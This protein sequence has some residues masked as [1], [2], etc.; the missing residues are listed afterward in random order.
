MKPILLLIATIITTSASIACSCGPQGKL[1]RKSVQYAEAVFVGTVVE[2]Y[3]D[4]TKHLRYLVFEVTESLKGTTNGEL[5]TITTAA[6]SAACG[7]SA[8]MKE[9][10]Y[11]YA[12]TNFPANSLLEVDICG[13]STRLSQLDLHGDYSR[14]Y[15]K[16]RK[17]NYRKKY[18]RFK[19]D[20]R[21]LKRMRLV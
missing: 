5:V 4:S 20:R 15:V 12:L 9:S 17:R 18:A 19:K 10:W 16:T 1:D 11:I 2:T 6:S 3:V 14:Q 13:R 8:K 21:L 7:I